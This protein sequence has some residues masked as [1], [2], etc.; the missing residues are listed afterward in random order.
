[1]RQEYVRLANAELTLDLPWIIDVMDNTMQK[2]YGG[3]PNMDF[4]IDPDGKLLYSK[5]WADMDVLKEWLEAN[6]GPSDIPEDEWAAL[7][8][9]DQ[10]ARAVGNNDEVPATEVPDTALHP[11]EVKRLDGSDAL[12]FSFEA[13]TLPPNITAEGQSRLYFVV[14]PD[15]NKGVSFDKSE[16]VTVDFAE[17]RGINFIK[18]QLQSGKRRGRGDDADDKD[19]YP[20]TLGVLWTQDG[21]ASRMEFKATVTASLDMGEEIPK[22]VTASYLVSGTLPEA[23]TI[24]DE[25]AASKIPAQ[26]KAVTCQPTGNEVVPMDVAAK[27]DMANNMLYLYLSVDDVGGHHWN[28]L[29]APPTVTLK[30]VSG[31]AVEKVSLTAGQHEGDSDKEDR[32]LVVPIALEPGASSFTIEIKP[33]AWICHDEEGWCRLFNKTYKITGKI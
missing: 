31:V 12:P 24:V 33:E 9:A 11:L 23:T 20:H 29:S 10:T 19:I 27:V 13:A 32:I 5:D 1:M 8:A 16:V 26:L 7:G 30:A 18:D 21:K 22:K 15:T 6:I 17:V 3:M 2:T 14:A 25:V 28:N 4:I